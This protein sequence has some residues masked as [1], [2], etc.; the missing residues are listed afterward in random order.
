MTLHPPASK[1]KKVG[2]VLIG[3]QTLDC[4]FAAV[5]AIKLINLRQHDSQERWPW[6]GWNV[7]C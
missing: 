7:N 6:S 2:A 5:L 4:E 3:S 1:T